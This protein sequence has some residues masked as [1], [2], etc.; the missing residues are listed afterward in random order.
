M[1]NP[2]VASA[3]PAG[4][5]TPSAGVPTAKRA[6]D[7]V[8]VGLGLLA[9]WPALLLI[10]LAI[11]LDSRGPVLFSQ[12]RIGH[13]GRPFRMW[14]FRSM[15]ADAEARRAAVLSASDRAGL[16]FKAKDDPRITRA[17]RFLRRTSLDELPQLWNVL[18]GEMSL[19]GPRPAL[20]EEVAAYPAAA[21]ERL[22]VLPGLTGVWQVSGRADVSFDDMVAMDVTYVRNP[23]IGRDLALIL[24]TVAVVVR[25]KGAY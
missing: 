13:G 20:P 9:I 21:R 14:K 8:L 7:I 25:G 22:A 2:L 24:R 23:G 4:R 16:C 10:A 1:A 19:V 5:L 17:G 15:V 12:V 11:R 18:K 3:A 6:L